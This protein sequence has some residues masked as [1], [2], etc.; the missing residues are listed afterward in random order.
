[1]TDQVTNFGDIAQKLARNPLGIIAL[2]IVLVYGFAALVTGFS[3][4]F[5][6]DERLPL[7]YFLII[8]PVLVLAVFAWLVSRH[9]NKL[10]AP[11]DF[12]NEDNYVKA[13]TATASLAVASAR[14]GSG[15]STTEISSVVESV[16]EAS[17]RSRQLRN[18]TSWWNHMLWVDDKPDNNIIER[19]AFEAMGIS[20]SLALSTDE[21]LALVRDRRFSAIISDVNRKEGPGEGYVLLDRLRESGD[22]TPFFI[23]GS[24][25]SA[26]DRR[27]TVDRG[28]QGLTNSPQ[29]LFG[30]VMR[31]ALNR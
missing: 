20:F 4:S 21:A 7:I 5:A 16:Q 30:I 31:A 25:N 13:L 29:E 15:V 28:G 9:S 10:F 27:I 12:R 14:G 18:W 24:S 11:S 3:G 8:F 6:P 19:N 23:Y 26:E 2:F 22:Q 1:M 17:A